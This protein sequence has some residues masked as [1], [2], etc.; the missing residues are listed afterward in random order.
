MHSSIPLVIHILISIV[1]INTVNMSH[2]D[3]IFM[4]APFLLTVH[5]PSATI[6]RLSVLSCGI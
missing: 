2:I 4:V 6:T 5:L 1:I 3:E